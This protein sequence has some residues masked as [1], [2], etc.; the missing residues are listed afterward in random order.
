M[1]VGGKPQ[2]GSEGSQS[3]AGWAT[4]RRGSYCNRIGLFSHLF[5]FT[6]PPPETY[7]SR[8]NAVSYK[9]DANTENNPFYH[10]FILKPFP[11]NMELKGHRALSEHMLHFQIFL[12]KYWLIFVYSNYFNMLHTVLN[13]FQ[14]HVKCR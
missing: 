10:I 11:C 13:Y 4:I 7:Y 3:C 9:T 2:V 5:S 14:L 1:R 6:N 12:I 8:M